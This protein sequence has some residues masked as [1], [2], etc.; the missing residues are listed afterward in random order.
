MEKIKVLIDTDIGD[1]IDDALALYFAMQKNIEIVGVT[2]VFKNTVQRA[3][4]VKK[5]LSLFSCGYEKVPV[6]AGYSSFDSEKIDDIKVNHYESDLEEYLIENT[7]PEKAVDF[8]IESCK[9]YGSTLTIVAIGPFTN[10]AKAIEKEP[11][12]F[13]KVKVVIMGGAYYSQYADWNVSCDTKSAKIVFD[14]LK[15]LECLGADVTHKLKI[16]LTNRKKIVDYKDK[17]SNA[18]GR[19][20]S[21][22]YA[23]FN[24]KDYEVFLHD[25]LAVYYAIDSS[26]CAMENARVEVIENGA[27]KG[28]TLN[29]EEY[30][31]EYLNSYYKNRERKNAIKV[32]KQV[33]KKEFINLFMKIFEM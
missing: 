6:Y 19:Y 18:V 20:L 5:I 30:N 7:N 21:K 27:G 22:V 32:A 28:I 3:Q 17:G 13:D 4:M 8:I 29:L 2:T 31:K 12:A 15:N 25:P 16:S 24:A 1:E 23:Q 26:V 9:K 14:N 10:I 33:K 11:S